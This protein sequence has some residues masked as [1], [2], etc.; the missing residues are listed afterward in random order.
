VLMTTINRGRGDLQ[1]LL[2]WRFLTII[3]LSDDLDC[4]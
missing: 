1:M 4:D 2:P 3:Q